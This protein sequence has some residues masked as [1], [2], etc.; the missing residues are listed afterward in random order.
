MIFGV[1]PPKIKAKTEIKTNKIQQNSS[2]EVKIEFWWPKVRS[3]TVLERHLGA[4]RPMINI[5]PSQAPVIF[6]ALGRPKVTW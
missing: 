5:G 2:E 4:Q 1:A 6:E 3:N